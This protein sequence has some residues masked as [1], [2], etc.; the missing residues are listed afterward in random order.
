MEEIPKKQITPVQYAKRRK[1]SLQAVTKRL[2]AEKPLKGVSKVEKFGR[3]YLLTL[4][5]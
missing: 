2:R 4:E 1:I 5:K 3:F